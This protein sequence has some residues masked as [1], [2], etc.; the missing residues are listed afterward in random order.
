MRSSKRP[1]RLRVT[2][3]ADYRALEQRLFAQLTREIY[4]QV[5]AAQRQVFNRYAAGSRADPTRLPVDWN[6]TFELRPASPRGG[7]P[8]AARH[9]G[10]AVLAAGA[11]RAS[12]C[13]RLPRG[14]LAP[15]G[16]RHGAGWIAARAL[17]GHGGS[18]APCCTRPA[19]AAGPR[20]AAVPGGLLERSCPGGRVRARPTAGRAAPAGGSP[21]V[22]VARG[23][24][25]GGRGAGGVAG[26]FVGPAGCAQGRL[27]RH[28]SRVRPVQVPVLLQST[29]AI[30]SIASPKPSPRGSTR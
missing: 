13:T 24:R 1:T 17:G 30:R 5:P 18:G 21:G 11:G 10:F 28:G 15:S 4:E 20:E 7:V 6:R 8:A 2:T 27:D 26:A 25:L 14:G 3:L 12:P 22:A 9:V 19:R 29:R 16:P 23:R